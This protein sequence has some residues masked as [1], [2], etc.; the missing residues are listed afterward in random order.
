MRITYLPVVLIAFG[1]WTSTRAAQQRPPETFRSGREVLTIDTSVR[2]ANGRPLTDLQPSDFSVRIDGEPRRVL[3][4]RLFGTN[5]ASAAKPETPVARFIRNADTPS[6]R[7]V[8]FAIDRD[9]I[10]P[11]SEKALLDTAASMLGTLSPADAVGA[12]G[13]PG[14][15]TD[16]TRDHAVVGDA[17]RRM[18]GTEPVSGGRHFISWP[19]AIGYDRKDAVTITA[20]TT[21][22]CPERDPILRANCVKELVDQAR[23]LLLAGHAHAETVISNLTRLLDNLSPFSAPK[24]VVLIS[25]GLPFDV[26]LLSRYQD[27]AF[28]AA[29]SHVALFVVHLDQPP[30][31]ASDRLPSAQIFGGR[32]QTEGLGNIASITGGL[33]FSGIGKATGA[34]DR[35]A[36]DINFFYELGV[37]SKASDADG[38]SHKIDV[39]VAREKATVRAPSATAL[40]PPS[41]ASDADILKHALAEPTDV[42]ELPLEVATYMT[43]SSDVE[44]VRVI[45]AAGVPPDAGVTPAQWGAVIISAGKVIGAVTGLVA[46]SAATPWTTT[47]TIDVVPGRYRVRTAIVDAAGR[48]GVLEVPLAV[49]LRGVGEVLMSDVILGTAS[50]GRLQP[51]ARVQQG[52]AGIGMI[53]LSSSAPL[54]DTTGFLQIVAAGGTTPALRRPLQLRTRADDKSIVVGEATLDLSLVPPGTYTASA[55][56]ERGGA[57]FARVSRVFDVLPGATTVPTTSASPPAAP[58]AAAHDPRL[59]EVLQR[60]G[61]YV[62]DYGQQASLLVGLE[63]Y[64]QSLLGPTGLETAHRKSNAEFALVK[65]ADAMGWAGFRDVIEVDGRRIGDRQNRLQTLFRGS[66]PDAGE[67]RRIADEGARFNLGPMR[68]NLNEPTAALFFMTPSLLPRFVFTR[69]GESSVNGVNVWEVEFKEKARPTLIRT[70]TGRDVPSEGTIWVVPSDGTVVRTR[71]AINGFVG[72][73]GSNIDVTYARDERLGL[74]LPQTMKERHES[75]AIE[76]G[77]SA[78]G[79]TAASR[80]TTVVVA[81]ATYADFKRFETSATFKIK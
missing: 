43:H 27:L 26:E 81:T 77:K 45:V 54:A 8:M 30:F 41:R 16:L 23:E 68:R 80:R 37:E 57:G 48:I 38:K 44:K 70:S 22:E 10:R 4:A 51:R 73:S 31:D 47:G 62:A 1:A 5:A 20:V 12:I 49:G 50:D 28:K 64:E 66:A 78:Y 19:E 13:L 21:R 75:E 15:A 72:A 2:D 52:E 71:L 58:A 60:V 59:S 18:T 24:H 29:Q 74:W 39:K 46:S 76:S 14:A 6:G 79:A 3:T 63:H 42:A 67:A 33:F 65:T 55:V 7:V 17:I 11:G 9:S 61:R 35:I 40:A 32:E 34:F 56:L 25:A 53:E 69:K 36:S